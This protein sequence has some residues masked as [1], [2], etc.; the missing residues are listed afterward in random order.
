MNHHLGMFQFIGLRSLNT[1][2]QNKTKIFYLYTQPKFFLSGHTVHEQAPVL[3]AGL[4]QVHQQS[5]GQDQALEPL[6]QGN[7]PEGDDEE[8]PQRPLDHT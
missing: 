7:K 1:N 5:Q 3:Q 8:T 4:H 2:T 6:A